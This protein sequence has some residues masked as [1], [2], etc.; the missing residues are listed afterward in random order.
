MTK[1]KG[2]KIHKQQQIQNVKQAVHIH[3]GSKKK[4][5]RKRKKARAFRPLPLPPVINRVVNTHI[6]LPENYSRPPMNFFEQQE[7][8]QRIKQQQ[9]LTQLTKNEPTPTPDMK[10]EQNSQNEIIKEEMK[11]EEEAV[12]SMLPFLDKEPRT[13]DQLTK[14]RALYPNRRNFPRTSIAIQE[15]ID[16]AMTPS[17][18]RETA[19]SEMRRGTPRTNPGGQLALAL[20]AQLEFQRRA[21]R[22]KKSSSGE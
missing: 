17:F 2:S 8:K 16:R 5:V 14:A 19:S 1:R 15:L 12:S 3:I 13:P 10:A 20:E 4:Y 7:L 18:A 22:R 6:V 9:Q 11:A 21:E